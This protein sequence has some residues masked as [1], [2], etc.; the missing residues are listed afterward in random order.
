MTAIHPTRVRTVAP[1]HFG[2]NFLRL[3]KVP[4]PRRCKNIPFTQTGF[5]IILLTDFFG[6]QFYSFTSIVYFDVVR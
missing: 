6:F 4:L 5:R 2:V 3:R 1:P